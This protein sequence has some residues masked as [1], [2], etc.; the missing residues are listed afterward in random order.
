VHLG[1]IDLA[2]HTTEVER[3]FISWFSVL[4][5]ASIKSAFWEIVASPRLP[6]AANFP[7]RMTMTVSAIARRPVP[8]PVY[9]RR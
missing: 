2:E 4:P 8:S 5:L 7:S 9:R 1:G 3:A 6:T